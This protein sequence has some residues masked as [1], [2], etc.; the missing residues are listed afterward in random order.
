[1]KTFGQSIQ[2]AQQA[3]QRAQQVRMAQGGAWLDR[4]RQIERMRQ[5]ARSQLGAPHLTQAPIRGRVAKMGAVAA[6]AVRRPPERAQTSPQ[7]PPSA[8]AVEI[9]AR[10]PRRVAWRTVRWLLLL[11]FAAVALGA[12]ALLGRGA[13]A[14]ADGARFRDHD[15]LAVTNLAVVSVAAALVVRRL[16]RRRRG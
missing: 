16:W 5:P 11:G 7:G 15:W 14:L 13:V 10:P 1:M 9:P 2:Q 3:R 12:L 6:F 8:G 4:K